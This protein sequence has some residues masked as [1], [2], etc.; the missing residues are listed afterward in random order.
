LVSERQQM[1]QRVE[2]LERSYEGFKATRDEVQE[3]RW[4]LEAKKF[5]SQV[6]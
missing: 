3:M 6:L 1:E 5:E 2:F 4:I